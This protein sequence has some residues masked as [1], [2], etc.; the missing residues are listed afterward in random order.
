MGRIKPTN[1]YFINKAINKHGHMFDYS[2]VEYKGAHYKVKIIC[3]NN[4]IFEQKPMDHWRGIGCKQCSDK[5]KGKHNKYTF[6]EVKKQLINLHPNLTFDYNDYINKNQIIEANCIKHGYIKKKIDLFLKGY[7]CEECKG[8]KKGKI[9]NEYFINKAKEQHN[10][11]YDYSLV[12]VSKAQVK[13]KI[14]C[15]KHGVFEQTPNS[16]T[17]GQG[18]P[19]CNFSK[20]ELKILN[21]LKNNDIEYLHQH[22]FKDCKYKR[23]LSFDFYLPK[24]NICIEYN[25]EYHYN[26]YEK[27]KG[28]RGLEL[29]QKRDQIKREFCQEKGIILLEIPYWNFKNL[30]DILNSSLRN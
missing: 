10:N 14:I 1:E 13:V 4:H 16:H 17:K 5:F 8:T 19:T 6:D 28:Q 30:E 29:V 2:L 22:K 15:P 7:G 9:N 23:Q 27:R 18:C 26:S 12:F 24:N 25:G 21:Y 20:G 11:Y 3:P